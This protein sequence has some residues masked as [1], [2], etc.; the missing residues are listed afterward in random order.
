M[1]T[2]DDYAR[3]RRAKRDGMSLREI[4]RRFHH[5]RWKIREALANAEPQK[6]TRRKQPP[7][8]KLGRFHGIIQEILAADE[9]A[10]RKQRHT[11]AQLLRRPMKEAEYAGGCQTVRGQ[12][13]Q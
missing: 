7:A 3:I 12:W 2:V 10:P 4:A 1:L 9:Q 6:Y 11:V 5:S 8:P 13:P